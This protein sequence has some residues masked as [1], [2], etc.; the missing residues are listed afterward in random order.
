MFSHI[1]AISRGREAAH[2]CC[3]NS[4]NTILCL[5]DYW[6]QVEIYFCFIEKGRARQK[7]SLFWVKSGRTLK[8]GRRKKLVCFS[9]YTEIVFL[10]SREKIKKKNLTKLDKTNCECPNVYCAFVNSHFCSSSSLYFYCIFL[11][12]AYGVWWTNT[13]DFYTHLYS[14]YQA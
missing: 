7:E 4:S 2:F 1:S 10:P 9:T 8:I 14:M 3:I 6:L 13:Y 11:L 12:W 5:V